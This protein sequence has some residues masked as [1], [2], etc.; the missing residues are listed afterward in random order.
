MPSPVSSTPT[1]VRLLDADGAARGAG[2]ERVNALAG[3]AVGAV[4]PGSDARDPEALTARS[5]A[6]TRCPSAVPYG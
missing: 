2:G 5:R 1:E 3:R 6:R 4:G